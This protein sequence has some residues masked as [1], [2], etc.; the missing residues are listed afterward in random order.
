MLPSLIEIK[1]WNTFINKDFLEINDK[2]FS[3]QRW[4]E[5]FYEKIVGVLNK[6]S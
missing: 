2:I 3:P 4:I 1:D 5:V 6:N